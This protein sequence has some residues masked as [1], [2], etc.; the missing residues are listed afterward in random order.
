MP[1]TE[2]IP[3]RGYT[4]KKKNVIMKERWTVRDASDCCFSE[5]EGRGGSISSLEVTPQNSKG[6]CKKEKGDGER[7]GRP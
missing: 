5:D 7:F 3:V 2:E 1:G 6:R 4:D